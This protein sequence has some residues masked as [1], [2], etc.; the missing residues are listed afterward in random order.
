MKFTALGC[1][2]SAQILSLD[3][4]VL[5]NHL[6]RQ[7]KHMVNPVKL[8]DEHLQFELIKRVGVGGEYLTQR[9]TLIYTRSEY[10]PLWPPYGMDMMEQIHQ[11]ALDTL[12]NHQ[13]PPL[14]SGANQLLDEILTEAD[15]VFKD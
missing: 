8:D 4:A 7:M 1:L 14:P 2:G 6:I 15:Q 9:E 3:K 5:D 13:P 10:I 11:E 12:H